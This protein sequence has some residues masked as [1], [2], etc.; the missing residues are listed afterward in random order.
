M[1]HAPEKGEFDVRMLADALATDRASITR[2]THVARRRGWMEIR[3]TYL[4]QRIRL[5]ELTPQGRKIRK[6][7]LESLTAD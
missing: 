3:T 6:K 2:I 5:G 4:S 1:C 7:L